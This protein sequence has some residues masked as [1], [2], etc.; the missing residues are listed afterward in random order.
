MSKN[1]II[2]SIS[3][4]K[5]ADQLLKEHYGVFMNRSMFIN[6]LIKKE[7]GGKKNVKKKKK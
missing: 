3:L 7:L 2:R 6:E 1:R 5:E 4:D